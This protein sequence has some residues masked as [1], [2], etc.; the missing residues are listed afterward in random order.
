MEARAL[1]SSLVALALIVTA[2]MAA[3]DADRK[4]IVFGCNT[5]EPAVIPGN[6]D[7]YEASPIQGM[8]IGVTIRRLE[9]PTERA[10]TNRFDWLAWGVPMTEAD[11]AES[12]R[13][14]R[15]RRE[16]DDRVRAG[17]ANRFHHPSSG[18]I[19]GVRALFPLDRQGVCRHDLEGQCPTGFSIRGDQ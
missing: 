13:R 17:G 3:P 7:R 1:P 10:K 12:I 9:K 5:Q 8:V 2:S 16:S 4:L 6:M 11:V 18:P 19:A 14:L 15:P